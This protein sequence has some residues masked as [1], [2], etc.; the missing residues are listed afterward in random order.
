MLNL[1]FWTSLCLFFKYFKAKD[2]KYFAHVS[3]TTLLVEQSLRPELMALLESKVTEV[4]KQNIAKVQKK[5]PTIL[6][7]EV[8]FISMDYCIF[9]VLIAYEFKLIYPL[10]ISIL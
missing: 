10:D 4:K 1:I 5:V 8:L 7:F 9:T 2:C 6:T 3:P